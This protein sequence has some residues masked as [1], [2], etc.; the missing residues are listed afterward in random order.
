MR[1]IRESLTAVAALLVLALIG[2]AVAPHFLDWN[3]HRDRL[4]AY[5]SAKTGQPVRLGG[6]IRLSLLP[7]PELDADAV[8]VGSETR[9]LVSIGRLT[10]SLS[11][12]AL[13]RGVVQIT[14]ARAD[15]VIVRAEIADLVERQKSEPPPRIGIDRLDLR[16]L[17]VLQAGT[18]KALVSGLDVVLEAPDLAGP[19]RF[20]V[21]D[22]AAGREVRGQ[23]GKFEQGRARLRASLEDHRLAARSSLEGWAGL[24]GDAT[25]PLFDGSV[26][27]SGNPIMGE[28]ADGTQI[29]FDGQARLIVQANQA[30]ADPVT[31]T[32][33]S[34][35]RAVAMNGKA[36]LDLAAARP[37]LRVEFAGRRLDLSRYLAEGPDG[38][39]ERDR[40]RRMAEALA[41]AN[42]SGGIALPLDLDLDIAIGALQGSGVMLQDTRLAMARRT[43]GFSIR[44]AEARLPGGTELEFRGT[45]KGTSLLDGAFSLVARDLPAL[46]QAIQVERPAGL[47]ASASLHST[48]ISEGTGLRMPQLRITSPSGD[49]AGDLRLDMPV[50]GGNPVP[51]LSFSLAADRFDARLL[52]LGDPFRAG[53]GT[54]DLAIDGRLAIRELVYDGRGIGGVR[55]AFNREGARARVEELVLSGRSGEELKLSGQFAEGAVQAT[56]KLDAERLGDLAQIAQAI[57]PGALTR[58]IIARAERLAPALAVANIRIE[59]KAGESIWDIQSEGRLGGTAITVKTHSELKGN[60]LQ[61]NLRAEAANPDGARLLSQIGGG[62]TG[63]L[64]GAGRVQLL[65]E[66]N[67]RR[68]MG[69]KLDVALAG[70][71]LKAEGLVDIFRT[72]PFDGTFRLETVDIAPLYRALG[73]GAPA[74][75]NGTPARIAGRYFAETRKLTLTA[76]DAT[77]GPNRAAGEISFD[78]ARGGQVAGQLQM[79]DLRLETLLS[80][81]FLTAEMGAPPASGT[82]RPLPRGVR[83]FLAGD[84]WIEAKSL[85]FG[86]SIV[87]DEPKFVLRFAPDLA[88][89]E[90]LEAEKGEGRLSSTVTLTRR[91]DRLDAAGRLAFSRLALPGTSGRLT[92]E[93][94]FTS[95]GS[96]ISELLASFAGAGRIK[97]EGFA[98]SA[99]E[100]GAVARVLKRPANELQPLDE[101]R[102]GSLLEQEMRNGT[103][104]LPALSMPITIIGG[105]ARISAPAFETGGGTERAQVLPS[106]VIDLPRAQYEARIGLRLANPPPQWRGALPET[107]LS[108]S[109]RVGL[110]PGEPRR[111]LSVSSLL[112]GLLAIHLQRD[113]ETIEGFE[114]DNRERA[115]FLR[116]SRSEAQRDRARDPLLPLI[117]ENR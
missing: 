86:E 41:G 50:S 114:A 22:R 43:A 25:R 98:V 111:V 6:D 24:P 21:M 66:G 7:T 76:F 67:P 79:G 35:D 32:F 30:I 1:I 106:L 68:Q 87:L 17:S 31:M 73:G 39:K 58:G 15:K 80:P 29:P 85:R 92:G 3:A 90:G 38:V 104:A 14:S 42:S 84:L 110:P 51:R 23:V 101:N 55:L 116:R 95:Q 62:D 64:S 5:L 112:N 70:L 63:G 78:F 71:D 113:L 54:S 69:T 18:E 33:G 48:L 37:H 75:P 74:V 8:T 9:S 60:D 103:L 109:G 89:I 82:A 91:E 107:A 45:E 26:Q 46:L 97:A 102:I 27:F 44:L 34:A 56:A 94:P 77:F 13:A 88:S 11:P 99:A 20:E 28:V 49:L 117:L 12:L 105:V 4:S 81:A 57:F 10:V 108:W 115:F 2:L 19:F 16:G 96:T 83:P 61:L 52:A 47:P 53:G 36:F 59:N 93:F 65:L 72:A 100:A 40:L